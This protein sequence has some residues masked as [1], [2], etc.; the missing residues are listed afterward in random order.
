M[1]IK[2]CLKDMMSRLEA[3]KDDERGMVDAVNVAILIGV[4]VIAGLIVLNIA[5]TT[6][7]S[8][9]VQAGAA[10]TGNITFN[11][12]N[13]ND[14]EYVNFTNGSNVYS[15]QF[16]LSTSS[17]AF[18]AG[19][20]YVNL[21]ATSNNSATAAANLTAAINA[22]ATLAGFLTASTSGN[23]TVITYDTLGTNGNSIGTTEAVG[24]AT[25]AAATLTGG[26]NASPL[27]ASQNSIL[28]VAQTG[29]SFIVILII[30][31][32]GAIA[33]GYVFDILPGKK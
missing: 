29:F 6:Y 19:S 7:T 20:I 17:E 11:G 28:G 2:K 30:A 4:V 13:V 25:W 5:N 31:F 15:L 12:G 24:N 33:I 22:N 26:V 8:A 14:T 21:S 18:P 16:N 32:I 9:A 10:A 1:D 27:A 3:K 23:S